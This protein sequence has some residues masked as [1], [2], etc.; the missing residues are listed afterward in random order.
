MHHIWKRVTAFA[1]L[2][3]SIAVGSAVGA[4]PAAAAGPIGVFEPVV[5][6]GLSFI[7]TSPFVDSVPPIRPGDVE[8]L[9]YDPG[10]KTIWM[11]DDS[12]WSL[13]EVDFV[14]GNPYSG[15]HR[16][17]I[18][19]SKLEAAPQYNNAAVL[20]GPKRAADLEA[21]AFSTG[22]DGVPATVD[23]EIY[24]FAGSCC[25]GQGRLPTVFRLTRD[26]GSGTSG[27]RVKDFQP[28][29]GPITDFSGAS[30]IG[31]VLHVG[32]KKNIYTYDYVS[33]TL[34]AAVGTIASEAAPGFPIGDITGMDFNDP[35]N[36][37]WVTTS[38]EKIVKMTWPGLNVVPGFAFD[39]RV[40]GIPDSRA[41][42]VIAGQ[43]VIPDGYDNYPT[44]GEREFALYVFN[45]TTAPPL[46]SFTAAPLA[47]GVGG[48]VT[49]QDT[50]I[51]RPQ[52][53]KWDYGDGSPVENVTI[54]EMYVGGVKN[55]QTGE[56]TSPLPVP[57]MTPP[58]T[59][60]Y[61]AIGTYTVKLTAE[62]DNGSTTTTQQITVTNAPAAGFT[63]GLDHADGA[64]PLTAT[65][66]DT[67]TGVP[68]PNAWSW[69]FGDGA[70]STD[71]NPS[72]TYLSSGEYT[73]TLRVT[74]AAGT[75]EISK[76]VLAF[77]A[78]TP[79]FSYAV[80]DPAVPLQVEFT[81]L[82]TGYPAADSL[83]WDFG[84]GNTL[85]TTDGSAVHTYVRGGQYEVTLTAKNQYGENVKK[86]LI[87]VVGKG[88][89]GI[90]PARVLDTR[91]GG[92]TADG[93]FQGGGRLGAASVLTVDIGGRV[94]IPAD[95]GA[96]ALNVTA[97]GP[98]GSSYLTVWPAGENRPDAS[99][100]NYTFGQ[101]IPNMVIV[102]L[103]AG[104]RV[105]FF[106][107][108]GLVD[109]AVDVLGFFPV[110]ESFHGVNPQRM[111]DT[112]GGGRTVD[113]Q[114][115]GVGKI[116]ADKQITIKLAGRQDVPANAGAVALNV[117]A[118]GG[119][120]ESYL[121]VWPAGSAQPNASNLNFKPGQVIPN[122]VI[123]PLSS[124]GEISIYNSAGSV[125]VLVDV[126]G[127]FP[128]QAQYSYVLRGV[129]PA[130][131]VDTR[132]GGNTVD[133]KYTSTGGLGAGA[134]ATY[135]LLGRG[136]L[137]QNFIGSVAL[138]VT[139]VGAT[140]ESYL[141]VWPGGSTRPNAS[142][143]N[144]VAG[145]TIPNMVIVPLGANGTISVYNASG[146]VDV[147]VDVLGYL[148]V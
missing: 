105:S 2:S 103:G 49:F 81:D 15:K 41:I 148:P 94:G 99:N 138:N 12:K 143:L 74:N 40:Q 53:L 131:L 30:A 5:A 50:S 31:N 25:T 78:P 1:V 113:Q 55:E 124:R 93:Q 66:T 137:P 126:L 44:H 20:A 45:V 46:A 95:A 65:F 43:V 90:N 142:N 88:F 110:G 23:D 37:L 57:Y 144:Y 69:S 36:E 3:A 133:T 140:S 27:F 73:V 107:E 70:G 132:Q 79:A 63:I 68:A 109:L 58:V 18:T 54:Q 67:S 96:V 4:D 75:S 130:R 101:T 47:V 8:G 118:V 128:P 34:S 117:T 121:T 56:I 145:T 97:I 77:G 28:L 11:S 115:Q 100:L 48:T 22:P 42:E 139:V 135:E 6:N 26:G 51:R 129:T 104:G 146:K 122:M 114:F 35:A 59:H 14:P 83:R 24:A 33:N 102:K 13:Y 39:S 91:G 61:T 64:V 10:R 123:V 111:L 52:R 86:M 98:S 60:T 29:S 32:N 127:W 38:N 141:T 119:S 21:M 82:S 9:A 71:R 19:T 136:P 112:R 89:V 120:A 85:T 62:N 17:T 7:K 80:P 92:A 76:K 106:N 134:T 125:D 72:H 147:I 84:D 108:A 87:I 116:G 16:R